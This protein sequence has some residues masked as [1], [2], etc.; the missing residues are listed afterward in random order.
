MSWQSEVDAA[1]ERLRDRQGL[2][3]FGGPIWAELSNVAA[4]CWHQG[5]QSASWWIWFAFFFGIIVGILI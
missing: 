3:I 1:V 5:R 4:A 2:E